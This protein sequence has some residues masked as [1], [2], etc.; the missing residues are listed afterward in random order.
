MH[1]KTIIF[2]TLLLFLW[3]P[4]CSADFLTG[5]NG[6]KLY[7]E[8]NH[9]MPTTWQ[10]P[11]EPTI[12]IH[13]SKVHKFSTLDGTHTI[14]DKVV[15]ILDATTCITGD[16]F[17]IVSANDSR[18]YVGH[19]VSVNSNDI[20]V[21]SPLDFAYPDGAVVACAN[22]NMAVDGSSTTQIFSLRSADP[23]GA[24]PVTVHITRV[25][26][27]CITDSA[28]S[29]DKFGNITALTHGLVFRQK[30][31][32]YINIFN[33]K[34]GIDLAGIGYDYE[35]YKATAPEQNVDGFAVRITFAGPSKM[36]SALE[37]GPGEDIEWLV[38]DNLASGPNDITLLK[39]TFEGHIKL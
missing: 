19:I 6:N 29:L 17:K 20:T 18:F 7:I 25:I 22:E 8:D 30:N 11:T 1:N 32:T 31:G 3:V 27:T 24:V 36:G 37:V 14:N 13:A 35:P 23:T 33:V 38:Q 4:I 26:I 5:H 34:S 28:T 9:S 15:S 16:S 10:D 12:I 21:D 39:V 2:T